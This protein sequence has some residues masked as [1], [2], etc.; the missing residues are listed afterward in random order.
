MK[1]YVLTSAEY[2]NH[3]SAT[4]QEVVWSLDNTK[5]I[6]E[7]SDDYTISNSIQEFS[8]ADQCNAWRWNTTTEE[9]RNWCSEDYWNGTNLDDF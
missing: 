8:D 7:V 3:T 1:Y 4:S 6:I 5:C 9:W 2:N